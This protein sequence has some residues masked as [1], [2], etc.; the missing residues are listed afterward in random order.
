MGRISLNWRNSL[1]FFFY[2][3]RSPFHCALDMNG[4]KID[5]IIE[6]QIARHS[7]H[8]VNVFQTPFPSWQLR[9][10]TLFLTHGYQ[11]IMIMERDFIRS[12]NCYEIAPCKI[13]PCKITSLQNFHLRNCP[14]W[15]YPMWNYLFEIAPCKIAHKQKCFFAKMR[16]C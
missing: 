3:L 7:V 15:N 9:Y 11:S 8:Y 4:N 1:Y 6:K 16:I 2:I 10:Q 14:F 12:G 5:F 13:T